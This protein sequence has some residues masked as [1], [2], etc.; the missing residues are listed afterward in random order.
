MPGRERP[1][2]DELR[3]YIIENIDRAVAEGWITVFYQPV[4]RTLTGEI[5][6][7]EALARWID[8][9]FGMI[10]PLYFIGI[11][12][13]AKLI[14][15]L[16]C[17]MIEKICED[18][19]RICNSNYPTG[20]VSFNLS[21]LDFSLCDIHTVI[22]DA[23]K[24]HQ[25]PREALRIEITESTLEA[26]S[27][28]MHGVID[29][30]WERGLR[31]WMDDFGSGYSSLN[32]LK[33]YHFDTLK[34]DMVFLRS[35][36]PRSREI[37]RAVVD[38]AKRIGIH[39]LAEGVE[40]AEQLEFL[41]N[42]GCEKAQG[43]YIGRPMPYDECLSYIMDSGLV[44][45]SQAKRKYFHDIGRVNVLSATPMNFL[46]EDVTCKEFVEE[47]LPL[48]IVE[49]TG[50]DI[51]YLFANDNYKNLL[52]EIGVGSLEDVEKD[53]H[54]GVSELKSKYSA[55]FIKAKSTD[56][57][58]S[59]DFIAG[60][61]FCYSR[62][63][64][65]SD[66]PGGNAFLIV[67]QDLTK[68]QATQK[69]A[70]VSDAMMSICN[71]YDSIMSVNLATGQAQG[72][73]T[74]V[75]A[76][77][78]YFVKPPEE[79]LRQYVMDEIY[80]DDREDYLDFLNFKTIEERLAKSST[81]HFSAPFRT[82]TSDGSYI[83]MLYAVIQDGKPE[84]RRILVCRRRLPAPAIA[85]LYGEREILAP[86]SKDSTEE[87]FTP[88]ILWKNFNNNSDTAFFW[89]DKE[90]RYV[91]ANRRFLQYFGFDSAEIII[92]RTDEELGWHVE[93]E[94]YRNDD[95]RILTSGEQTYLLP[96]TCICKGEIR[97]VLVCKWPIYHAG[98]IV[99]IMGYFLDNTDETIGAAIRGL[100]TSDNPENEMAEI[101]L[102]AT[103]A[104]II[105]F[106]EA[107]LAS[108]EDFVLIAFAISNLGSYRINF[109]ND[110]A[111]QVL[112]KVG[113]AI[114]EYAGITGVCGKLS[115]D[116][117]VV[118]KRSTSD[119]D[120]EEFIKGA[121]EAAESLKTVNGVSCT[122]YIRAGFERYSRVESIQRLFL[123]AQEDL[124]RQS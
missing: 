79:E 13:E 6:G 46:S 12:E 68:E 26:D 38:M 73:Y 122:P 78:T 54:D 58:V 112:A 107:Y 20:S 89:K 62:V 93:P 99:G 50:N 82:R 31:V 119:N 110:F 44:V 28:L 19:E 91:G 56:G 22:E 36:D 39:T 14:H 77:A 108:K 33:D 17:Y 120:V 42:I 24:K 83:W 59:G 60:T 74:P 5:C 96:G 109:G 29:K 70:K 116:Q 23:V 113:E 117:Y 3:K 65:I 105:R 35:F 18:F 103:A 43:Y 86:S 84:D 97:Q 121:K 51:K 76:K 55:L 95:D 80:P 47:Q 98:Q 72:I 48:A 88:E 9:D 90:R 53:F 81:G 124:L 92:G 30:F 10:S 37:I 101:G 8:P 123:D 21:R 52:L 63:R 106:Q 104:N 114:R 45:E 75:L 7:M 85:R 34:I 102:I 1:S 16:D 66:F 40:T 94:M 32:V 111:N 64:A 15:K 27:K 71:I 41:K 11:L 57:I 118:L 4:V 115:A 49:Y 61:H 67:L 100:P 25:V 87:I 2:G 69:I